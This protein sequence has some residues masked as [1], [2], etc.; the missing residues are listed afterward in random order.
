MRCEHASDP[1]LTKTV[2]A[3]EVPICVCD[4]TGIK[5]RVQNQFINL[6]RCSSSLNSNVLLHI[7][8]TA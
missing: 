2:G 1:R 4:G 8:R 6:S 7:K 3:M 5:E